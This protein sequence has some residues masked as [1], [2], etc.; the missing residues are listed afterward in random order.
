M[1]KCANTSTI[2]AT[3]CPTWWNP[4]TASPRDVMQKKS[5]SRL[6][7]ASPSWVMAANLRPTS[8]PSR[9][10]STWTLTPPRAATILA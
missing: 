4:G 1:H 6:C 3:P 10:L 9:G 5:G 7:Q 2:K 8:L